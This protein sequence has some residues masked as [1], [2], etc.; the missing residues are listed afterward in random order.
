MIETAIALGV[1]AIPEGLPIVTT[2][3]LARGMYL[4]AQKNAPVN[5]LQAVE[6][7]GATGVIFTDKTGTLTENHMSLH[8]IDSPTGEFRIEDHKDPDSIQNR[9]NDIFRR[10][11]E[12]GVLCNNASI[13]DD[14]NDQVAEEEQGDPTETALL[15]AGLLLSINREE[16]LEKKPELREEAFSSDTMMMATY[17]ESNGLKEVAVK[18]APEKLMDVCTRIVGDVLDSEND[19][20]DAE[21][22]KWLKRSD[23]LAKNGLR[24]LAA[25]DKFVQNEDEEPYKELRFLGLIG[26][27]DPARDDVDGAINECQ[28]AGIRVVMVTGD[29]AFTA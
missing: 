15:R 9:E 2:I 19:F 7:L 20:T 17:H 1:T 24:L 22:E 11:I 21:K 4:L 6:T 26:L 18:G 10:I 16:L 13:A 8:T 14:D 28:S 12:V 25:A 23:K 27:L 29:Q 3:A 5:K